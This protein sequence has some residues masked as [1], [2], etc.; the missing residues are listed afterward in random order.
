M[1]LA[2]VVQ[3]TQSVTTEGVVATGTLSCLRRRMGRRAKRLQR[4]LIYICL[5]QRVGVAKE[6]AQ[7]VDCCGCRLGDADDDESGRG[8]RQAA[9]VDS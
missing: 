9:V 3:S 6:R 1:T 2:M 4:E 7:V 8:Q 5:N